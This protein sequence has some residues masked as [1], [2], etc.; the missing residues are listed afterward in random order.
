MFRVLLLSLASL[1][2]FAATGAA[3][4]DVAPG[5]YIFYYSPSAA[6]ETALITI[7]VEHKGGKDVVELI[8][9]PQKDGEIDKFDLDGKKVAMTFHVRGNKNSFDFEGAVSANDPKTILG[10]VA[11]GANVMRAML[12]ATDHEKI[13]TADRVGPNKPPEP[14]QKILNLRNETNQ[15]VA[16]IR[17]AQEAEARKELIAKWQESRKAVDEQSPALF[18]ELIEKHGESVFILEAVA[19]FLPKA[20]Q[21]AKPNEVAAWLKKI[22]AVAEPYG[23]RFRS[24]VQFKCEQLSSRRKDSNHSCWQLPNG[25]P[26]N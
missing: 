3:K 5:N 13:E 15:I 22:D 20:G 17:A 24:S 11:V 18:R 2:G 16:K 6:L 25:S 1:I 12:V 9:A 23:P 14:M 19:S 10:N 7:K 8:D 26:R 21:S 4:S